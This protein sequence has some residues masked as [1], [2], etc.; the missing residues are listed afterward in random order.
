LLLLVR[1]PSLYLT[2]SFLLLL[3]LL[4]F[5]LHPRHLFSTK[6]H[7]LAPRRFLFSPPPPFTPHSPNLILL[8]HRAS[9]RR[10]PARSNRRQ[11]P[12]ISQP[13]RAHS[14]HHEPNRLPMR[15]LQPRISRRVQVN[16]PPLPSP[17]PAKSLFLLRF[18]VHLTRFCPK[19]VFLP[20][21]GPSDA[22]PLHQVRAAWLAINAL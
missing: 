15:P 9:Q 4:L 1:K 7:A 14:F 12:F 17:T 11:P 18:A 22:P 16:P 3:L 8:H 6:A 10:C 20:T 2:A 5:F 21:P 13:S 19:P